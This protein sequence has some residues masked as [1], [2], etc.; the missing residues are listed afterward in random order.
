[1]RPHIVTAGQQLV[2]QKR[3]LFCHFLQLCAELFSLQC[4]RVNVGAQSSQ[5]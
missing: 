5:I 4:V 1:M 2:D 3:L